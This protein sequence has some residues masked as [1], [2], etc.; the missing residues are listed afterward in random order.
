MANIL[1]MA[2]ILATADILVFAIAAPEI[3]L[4]ARAK[5]EMN[6]EACTRLQSPTCAARGATRPRAP[7]H[8]LTRQ[9][10]KLSNVWPSIGRNYVLTIAA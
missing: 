6:D 3:G 1:V 2:D 10:Q 9:D 8:A 4:S 7:A 5:Y